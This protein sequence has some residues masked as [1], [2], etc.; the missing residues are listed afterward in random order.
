MKQFLPRNKLAIW[1]A[2]RS[3]Y[4]CALECMSTRHANSLQP[5]FQPIG[6]IS[7]GP[8]LSFYPTSFR[9]LIEGGIGLPK[10]D[11]VFFSPLNSFFSLI[12]L[13]KVGKTFRSGFRDHEISGIFQGSLEAICVYMNHHPI[14]AKAFESEE[15]HSIAFRIHGLDKWWLIE[16]DKCKGWYS[17]PSNSQFVASA[18]LTFKNPHAARSASLGQLN[19]WLGITRGEIILSGRIPLLDKFGYVARI[20]QREVPRP[21]S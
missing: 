21:P 5:K 1:A 9:K 20:A 2:A 18:S 15:T 10:L 6:R 16:N 4:G 7:L 8:A 13:A 12:N 11:G 19:N 17:R 3:I 14:A